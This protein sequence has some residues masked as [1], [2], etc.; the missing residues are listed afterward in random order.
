[1]IST[2]SEGRIMGNAARKQ[3]FAPIAK[4]QKVAPIVSPKILS[5]WFAPEAHGFRTHRSESSREESKVKLTAKEWVH[6]L[7]NAAPVL[8]EEVCQL[9]AQCHRPLCKVISNSFENPLR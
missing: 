3:K 8:G 9:M 6:L 4:K 7:L 1:M 2:P 5:S